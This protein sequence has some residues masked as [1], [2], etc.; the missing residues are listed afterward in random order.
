[1]MLLLHANWVRHPELGLVG[2]M[3]DDDAALA[4]EI[5]PEMKFK[6]IDSDHVIHTH[7]PEVFIREMEE[8]NSTLDDE[9]S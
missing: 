5:A 9:H 8:F 2:A 3:D 7:E 6:R 4:R 1:P